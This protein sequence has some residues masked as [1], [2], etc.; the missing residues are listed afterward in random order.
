MAGAGLPL[1]RIETRFALDM[2]YAGQT[3]SIAVPL[4]EDAPQRL[5]EALVAEAF[6]AAYRREFSRLLP[7]LPR[8]I[9]SLR[10]AAIGRRP[11]FD[12]GLLA[13]GP[14]A[15]LAAAGRG[16]RPVWFEGAWRETPVLARLELSVGAAI[17][18]PAI[19]EE[20]DATIVVDP[21]L[22]ARVDPLGNLV[23]ERL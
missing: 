16:A 11:A 12:L 13:P 15:S 17:E 6:E 5:S 7:G 2:H 22:A 14:E 1:E 8:R 4:P 18:G 9:V 10:T 19:L 21:G 23:I 20:P 3:H